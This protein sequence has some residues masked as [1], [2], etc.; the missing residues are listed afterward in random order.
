VCGRFVSSTPAS[1]LAEQFLVSDIKVAELAAR[2]NVAPTDE[3]LAVATSKGVRRLG[4]FSWGLVPSWSKDARKG[5]PLVNL[6][7]DTVMTRPAFRRLL[8]AH[9]CIVPADGFYEWQAATPERP[10]RPVFIHRRDGQPLALAGLWAA[11]RA[12]DADDDTAWLRT[13]TIITAEPNELVAP[14]HDRM[15]VI[16]PPESWD[17]WLD[18]TIDDTAML[19]ELLVAHPAEQ[20]EL[21]PV[22]TEVNSVRNDGP[23]LVEPVG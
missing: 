2:W 12:S 9:R 17:R 19:G 4:S 23:S 21:W 11:W 7:A 20:M 16:L 18:S 14:V 10:K 15:P 8:A 5:R 13:C 22:S 6:R 1:V 3:V